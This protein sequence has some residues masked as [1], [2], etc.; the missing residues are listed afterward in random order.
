MRRTSITAI[1]TR[2]N[3]ATSNGLQIGLIRPFTVWWPEAYIRRI[4]R[5]CRNPHWQRVS[6]REG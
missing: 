1:S 2:S 5:V 6:V 3:V 4:G